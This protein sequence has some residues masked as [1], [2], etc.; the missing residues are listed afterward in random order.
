MKQALAC[1]REAPAGGGVGGGHQVGPRGG[2]TVRG[3]AAVGD[4]GGQLGESRGGRFRALLPEAEGASACV[5]AR[6]TPQGEVGGGRRVGTRKGPAIRKARPSEMAMGDGL[7][8]VSRDPC[9]RLC[10]L[11][12]RARAQGSSIPRRGVCKTRRRR[13]RER[14]RRAARVYKSTAGAVCDAN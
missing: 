12:W 4:D 2:T 3:G 11:K 7:H 10:H 6:T 13:R 14:S 8:L 1:H 9:V 5:C